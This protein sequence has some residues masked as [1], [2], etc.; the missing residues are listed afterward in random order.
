M[1]FSACFGLQKGKGHV[2]A[3]WVTKCTDLF[4]N[5][6]YNILVTHGI[7]Y[8]PFLISKT[9]CQKS[10]QDGQL[11]MQSCGL[12]R[13]ES[14]LYC[15]GNGWLTVICGTLVYLEPLATF[16]CHASEF[17]KMIVIMIC[18]ILLTSLK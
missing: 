1:F 12:A 3:W 18:I 16:N 5:H 15:A 17:H 8:M 7:L 14:F 10:L 9:E 4:Y 11:T 13:E 6:K 2:Y